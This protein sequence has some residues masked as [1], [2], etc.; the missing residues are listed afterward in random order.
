MVLLSDG[1]DIS[2]DRSYL[3]ESAQKA[4]EQ[5]V[6]VYTVGIGA[7]QEVLIPIRSPDQSFVS[8]Y[9]LSEDG[10]YLK[11]SL[12]PETLKQIAATTGGRYFRAS[13]EGSAEKLVE[14]CFRRRRTWKRRRASNWPGSTSPH[15]SSG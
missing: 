3:N 4:V 14:A 12:V 1:E 6:K 8:G 15:P 7:S 9:Y 5:K 10:S 11:T 13:E 2:L